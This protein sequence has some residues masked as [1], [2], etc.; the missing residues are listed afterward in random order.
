MSEFDVKF[1]LQIEALVN[2]MFE[3]HLLVI[4]AH[5]GSVVILNILDGLHVL[6]NQFQQQLVPIDGNA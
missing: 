5:H 6:S 2:G 1:F 3:G 4:N